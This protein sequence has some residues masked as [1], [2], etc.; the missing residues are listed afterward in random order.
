MSL[1]PSWLIYSLRFSLFHCRF[2]GGYRAAALSR[3]ERSI[4]GLPREAEAKPV[5]MYS[6]SSPATA[7]SSSLG[8]AHLLTDE[9]AMINTKTA[10]HRAFI[11]SSTD[12]EVTQ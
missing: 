9:G 2:Q 12:T 3:K 1:R 10:S 4:I 6:V 8:N 11:V 5:R 7:L